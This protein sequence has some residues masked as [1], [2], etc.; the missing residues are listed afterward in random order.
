MRLFELFY[1]DDTNM[2][3]CKILFQECNY[4]PETPE[5]NMLCIRIGKKRKEKREREKK[6]SKTN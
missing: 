4:P 3:F 1:F 6:K 5:C 2:Q